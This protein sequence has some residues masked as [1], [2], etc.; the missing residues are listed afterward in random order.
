MTERDRNNSQI[1]ITPFIF[2][3]L[4]EIGGFEP[5]RRIGNMEL[6]D[7]VLLQ[8]LW[9]QWKLCIIT[10]DYT[11]AHWGPA[12]PMIKCGFKSRPGHH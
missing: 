9:I 11:W 12:M 7:S 3:C 5:L 6:V 1:S 10:A 4:A 8:I 2:L